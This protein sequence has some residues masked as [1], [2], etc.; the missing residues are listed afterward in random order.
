MVD[1]FSSIR[2]SYSESLSRL[3]LL[4]PR[5]VF[6]ELLY[7]RSW[8]EDLGFCFRMSFTNSTSSHSLSGEERNLPT[9]ILSPL[10]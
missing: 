2:P 6:A 8:N 4:N 10:Q 5:G 9:P 3:R 1:G 7:C